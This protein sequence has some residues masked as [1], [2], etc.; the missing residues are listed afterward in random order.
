MN[1]SEALML[2]QNIY[3]SLI[4]YLHVLYWNLKY[5]LSTGKQ[6]NWFV[7][8]QLSAENVGNISI[9]KCI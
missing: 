7:R 1:T 5:L 6:T 2:L 4:F 8:I 9:Y 3:Q